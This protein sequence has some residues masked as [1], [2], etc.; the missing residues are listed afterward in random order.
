MRTRDLLLALVV[1]VVILVVVGLLA[2]PAV[3]Y[4][5]GDPLIVK[6][7]DSM[8]KCTFTVQFAEPTGYIGTMWTVNG[9]L[10]TPK[11][12]EGNK[13]FE[14]YFPEPGDYQ[15]EV[16]VFFRDRAPAKATTTFTVLPLGNPVERQ[17]AIVRDFVINYVVPAVAFI[18]ILMQT[19]GIKVV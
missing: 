3:A 12:V 19:F 11:I 6:R 10:R 17:V 7:C 16:L 18:A 9:T 15:V 8:G 2:K 13:P 1:A 5:A 4:A 14:F